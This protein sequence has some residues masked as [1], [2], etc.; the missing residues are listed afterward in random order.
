MYAMEGLE[1]A[2]SIRNQNWENLAD[3]SY[4]LSES[5]GEWEFSGSEDQPDDNQKYTRQITISPAQRNDNGDLVASGG[6]TDA[7]TKLVVVS[8]AWD[9]VP[10]RN[11]EVVLSKYF[12]NWQQERN[13]PGAAAPEY[14]TCAEYCALV[15]FNGGACRSNANQCDNNNESH[16]PIGD[17]FCSSVSSDTCC[18]QP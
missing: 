5:G 13:V 17:T 11:N 7:D 3:G 8:V 14:G 18:C 4:G 9:F 16:K 15:D 12:T 6:T 1:A 2:Q 10:T